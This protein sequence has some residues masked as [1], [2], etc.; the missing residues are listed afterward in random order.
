MGKK[1]KSNPKTLEETLATKVQIFKWYNQLQNLDEQGQNTTWYRTSH[2]QTCKKDLTKGQSFKGHSDW[3]RIGEKT[4]TQ[5]TP[6]FS[7]IL[8]LCFLGL[9]AVVPVFYTMERRPL[10]DRLPNTTFNTTWVKHL[11]AKQYLLRHPQGCFTEIS[12]KEVSAHTAQEDTISLAEW[13]LN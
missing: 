13:V 10:S 11:S 3:Q 7:F 6:K 4:K 1:K 8:Q 12:S 5:I 2:A 9:L